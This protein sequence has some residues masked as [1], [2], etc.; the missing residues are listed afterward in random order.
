MTDVAPGMLLLATPG[1]TDPNFAHTVV[2]LLNAD[3]EGV[4]GV[5]LNR[6]SQVPVAEI[7]EVGAWTPTLTSP[8]VLFKGGPVSVEGAIAVAMLR[9]VD[10]Q[11]VGF[12]SVQG[13]LGI[14][15]LDTPVALFEGSLVG[16]RIF[17]GYAGWDAEQ[18]RGE[19]ARGDW[20]VAAGETGDFFRDDPSELWRDVMRRQPGQL[21]WH[22]TRPVD[23]DL[24]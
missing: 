12:R 5:V 22:S 21:A 9:D 17:A 18:L 6:P 11:P 7:D 20:Y 10:D 23:P 15:D 16:M 19:I 2:L 4:L 3:E 14:V 8:E 13:R 1:L 24:N